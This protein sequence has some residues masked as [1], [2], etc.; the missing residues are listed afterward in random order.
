MWSAQE[1]TGIASAASATCQS[2]IRDLQLPLA[3]DL[4]NVIC[5]MRPA[6]GMSWLNP[7]QGLP[8]KYSP[9]SLHPA[10]IVPLSVIPLQPSVFFNPSS[11]SY[12]PFIAGVWFDININREYFLNKL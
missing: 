11:P 8:D 9:R 2:G 12:I 4:S 6:K 1:E 7:L 10:M 3:G 5:K